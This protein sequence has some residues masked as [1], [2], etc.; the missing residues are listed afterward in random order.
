M[1]KGGVKNCLV[2]PPSLNASWDVEL[3][4]LLRIFFLSEPI[5]G[6]SW[7]LVTTDGCGVLKYFEVPEHVSTLNSF[8]VWQDHYSYPRHDLGCSY[9]LYDWLKTQEFEHVCFLDNRGLGY[10]PMQA[11][12]VGLD[13]EQTVFSVLLFHSSREYFLYSGEDLINPNWLLTFQAEDK[14]LF[15]ADQVFTLSEKL[16][17]LRLEKLSIANPNVTVIHPF[18]ANESS[19]I[20]ELNDLKIAP[21]SIY[22]FVLGGSAS[23]EIAKMLEALKKSGVK[24]KC[25]YFGIFSR[26]PQIQGRAFQLYLENHLSPLGI[27]F[28]IRLLGGADEAAFEFKIASELKSCNAVGVFLSSGNVFPIAAIQC[29]EHK[30]PLLVQDGVGLEEWILPEYHD[31]VFVSMSHPRGFAA[32]LSKALEGTPQGSVLYRRIPSKCL[33]KNTEDIKSTAFKANE[34]LPFLSVCLVHRNRPHFLAM[35]LESLRVQSYS[36]FEVILVDDGSDSGDAI[37]M[38]DSLEQEFAEREWKILRQENLY[39]GAARN[40][41]VREARGEYVLFMDDDNIALPFEIE[42]FAKVAAKTKPD[43][44]VCRMQFFSGSGLPDESNINPTH[45]H[46]PMGSVPSLLVLENKCGDANSLF[47]KSSFL[48]LG[49]FTEDYGVGL[50]DY[51]LFLKADLEG[52]RIELIPKILFQYRVMPN[53]MLRSTL[54]VMNRM[55]QLRPT[56]ERYSKI[57]DLVLLTHGF[58]SRG[59]DRVGLLGEPLSDSANAAFQSLPLRPGRE[60]WRRTRKPLLS[61]ILPVRNSSQ[62]VCEAIDSILEQSF[63]DFT[64]FLVDDASTDRGGEFID[65]FCARDRRIQVLSSSE[66]LGFAAAVNLGVSRCTT[67][68]FAV[69]SADDI[70]LPKRIE[71]Q[72]IAVEKNPNLVLLG[73]QL[74]LIDKEA[75][76]FESQY[77]LPER[78]S[79]IESALLRFGWPIEFSSALV[80]LAAYRK[81]GGYKYTSY[82]KVF[83][84]GFYLKLAELG[85]LGNLGE[86]LVEA[87]GLEAASFLTPL[88]V[89][90]NQRAIM[91]ALLRR[92]WSDF[93]FGGHQER[94]GLF[95]TQRQLLDTLEA[96][97][98]KTQKNP[99]AHLKKLLYAQKQKLLYGQ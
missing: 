14:S 84:A 70:A 27:P 61:V 87:R 9:R 35:A 55:R 86:V 72:W 92:G 43:I 83:D 12:R 74:Q 1:I 67:P 38:L 20:E 26:T 63:E 59:R 75:I 13:F 36:H 88:Q 90:L 51:E 4:E 49:G 91:Q 34:E 64:L 41:A 54:S 56:L 21:S 47:K 85:E 30:L 24:P 68:W 25:I 28:E 37:Q 42:I 11:K 5:K 17:E 81:M 15:L 7:L 48:E 53:S 32:K 69:M 96:L 22:Q 98:K 76:P 82:R 46:A 66:K 18:S 23:V 94:Y 19:A 71:R 97:W 29:L 2:L 95:G 57:S 78:H 33:N 6:Q 10:I 79:E 40:R 89:S 44:A 93:D 45:F 60:K 52:K 16:S 50:E 73:S 80:N 8:E 99:S 31:Q 65:E 62:H 58:Y 39:L 77:L 3:G